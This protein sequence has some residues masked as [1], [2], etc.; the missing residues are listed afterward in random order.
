MENF[1]YPFPFLEV[2]RGAL[3]LFALVFKPHQF[4]LAISSPRRLFPQRLGGSLPH[5]PRAA[6]LWTTGGLAHPLAPFDRLFTTNV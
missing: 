4:W 3:F 2:H 1:L 6:P 5:P